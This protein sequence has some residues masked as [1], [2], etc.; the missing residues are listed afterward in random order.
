MRLL[1]L[2]ANDEFSLTEFV[3]NNI[4]P[5]AILSHTWGVDGEEA[6]FKDLVEGTGKSKAGYTKI[7]FC[8][9]Q[10]ARDGLQY[11]WVDTCCIDKSSSAELQEAIISMFQWYHNAAKCCVYLSDVSIPDDGEN[12]QFSQFTWESVFCKSRWFTRGWTLQELIAPA[13]V[14]F[15]SQEGRRLGDK[16]SLERQI[17]E[18]TGIPIQALRGSPPSHFSIGERMSWAAKRKTKRK[19]DKAYC[20]LGIFNIYMPLIYGE[21]DNAFIRLKEEID[22]ALKGKH[23][24]P[25]DIQ[26]GN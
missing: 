5:Y 17:Y 14:E 7:R 25:V 4:P 24:I 1:E 22:K 16:K 18:I 21:G 12:D 10:A 11:F 8:G 23:T 19:E 9:K 3:G 2:K 13:L 20:L 26:H 15:F 6:T